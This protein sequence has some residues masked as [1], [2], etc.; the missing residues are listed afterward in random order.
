MAF[1]ARNVLICKGSSLTAI[2]PEGRREIIG[3]SFC[4]ASDLHTVR[5]RRGRDVPR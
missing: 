1:A 2:R 4:A 5:S 3:F